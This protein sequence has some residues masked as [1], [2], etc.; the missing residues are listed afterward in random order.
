[1]KLISREDVPTET[2]KKLYNLLLNAWDDPEFIFCTLAT[3]RGD[4]N[5]Q[6]L[7]NLI[8]EENITDSDTIILAADDIA[9]GIEI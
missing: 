2:G 8:E 5:K 1:M 7:I 6:K 9:D 4:E 3:L